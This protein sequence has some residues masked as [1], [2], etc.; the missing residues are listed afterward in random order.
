MQRVKVFIFVVL[1]M[2]MLILING[3]SVLFHMLGYALLGG[4]VSSLVMCFDNISA[5][6]DKLE[7]RLDD[8]EDKYENK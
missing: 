7:R 3:S 8:L 4:L 5:K 1:I 6:L 2:V